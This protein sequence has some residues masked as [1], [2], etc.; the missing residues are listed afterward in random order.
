[1][2]EL[3]RCPE[4]VAEYDGVAPRRLAARR[5]ARTALPVAAPRPPPAAPAPARLL[6][7]LMAPAGFRVAGPDRGPGGD[8]AR[9]EGCAL[10][11]AGLRLSPRHRDPPQPG[12]RWLVARGAV[13]CPRVGGGAFAPGRRWTPPRTAPRAAGCSSVTVTPRASLASL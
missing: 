13:L 11:L 3:A 10:P 2:E 9:R 5:A 4:K 12:R 8:G 1:M 6:A 7:P